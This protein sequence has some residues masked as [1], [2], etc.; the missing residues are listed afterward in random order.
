MEPAGDGGSTPRF[1]AP[2]D[3]PPQW[4]PP[5]NSGNTCIMEVIAQ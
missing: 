5:V 2:G 1:A 4:S 3:F